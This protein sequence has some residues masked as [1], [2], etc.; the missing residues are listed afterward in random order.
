MLLSLNPLLTLLTLTITTT[1]AATIL[2]GDIID[3]YP[4]ISSLDI[5]DIPSNKISRYW[6]YAG[7]QAGSIP[8]YLPILVARGTNSSLNTGRK[9]SLSASLHGDELNGVSVVHRVFRNE[10]FKTAVEEGRFNGTV[11]GLPTLNPNGNQHSQRLFYSGNG[12]GRWTD[13][14]SKFPGSGTAAQGFDLATVFAYN[15]WNGIWGNTANVDVAVDFRGFDVLV[16][17]E[18]AVLMLYRWLWN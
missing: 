5:R 13:L 17:W 14:N 8:L 3:T 7:T 4:V 10:T 18:C 15:I 16:F 1:L 6:F 11:I 2:T 9:L 12:N